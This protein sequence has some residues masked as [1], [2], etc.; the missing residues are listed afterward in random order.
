MTSWEPLTSFKFLLYHP[1]NEALLVVPLTLPPLRSA[2]EEV[3]A[4]GSCVKVSVLVGT[5]FFQV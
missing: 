3:T 4:F 1:G 2:W 5:G